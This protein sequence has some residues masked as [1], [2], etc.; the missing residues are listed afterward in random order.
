MHLGHFRKTWSRLYEAQPGAPV[1]V[2][3]SASL[4]QIRA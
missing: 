4:R 2:F 3:A 1:D